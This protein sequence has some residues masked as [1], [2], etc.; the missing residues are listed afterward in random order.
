MRDIPVF[1]TQNG[2]GSLFLSQVPYTKSAFIKIQDTSDAKAFLQECIDFCRAVDASHIYISGHEICKSFPLYTSVLRMR[3]HADTI[4]DTDACLLPITK[5]TLSQWQEIYNQKIKHVP[6]GRW[7]NSSFADELLKRGD[8]YFVHL[9]GQLIG[10][11]IAYADHISWVCSLQK[12]S[13]KEVVRA[14]IHALSSDVIELEV[15]STNYKAVSLY[16]E[17]G[18]TI[19]EIVSDWYV[20]E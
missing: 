6:N 14:L 7:M 20:V 10:T 1:S 18:F 19:C 15:A 13:G 17:L 8:G 5:D 2:V 11:G 16:E 9:N 3:A 4:G 12:A